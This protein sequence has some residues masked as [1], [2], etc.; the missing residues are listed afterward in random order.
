LGDWVP[1]KVL[2][3]NSLVGIFDERV[4]LDYTKIAGTLPINKIN[5]VRLFYSQAVS[6][7][8]LEFSMLKITIVD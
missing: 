2:M 8:I 3:Y 4:S 5:D 7:Y 1:S 6:N